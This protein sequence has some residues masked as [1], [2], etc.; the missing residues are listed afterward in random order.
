MTTRFAFMPWKL[1]VE[2]AREYLWLYFTAWERSPRPWVIFVPGGE[3]HEGID[4]PYRPI[5]LGRNWFRGCVFCGG[6]SADSH[7]EHSPTSC[8]F[9]GLLEAVDALTGVE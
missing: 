8:E 2:E 1:T 9:R 7:G 3:R 5:P 4:R 6:R